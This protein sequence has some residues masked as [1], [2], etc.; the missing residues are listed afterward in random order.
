MSRSRDATGAV[1][2]AGV[3]NRQLKERERERKREGSGNSSSS[4]RSESRVHTGS[5]GLKEKNAVETA[6]A[7]RN[8]SHSRRPR[9]ETTPKRPTV[10]ETAGQQE[11]SPKERRLDST[12]FG[13]EMASLA[14]CD[15]RG[16][17]RGWDGRGGGSRRG[18]DRNSELERDRGGIDGHRSGSDSRSLTACELTGSF[19]RMLAAMCARGKK[20]R[21]HDS[22]GSCQSFL[23]HALLSLCLC[24]FTKAGAKPATARLIEP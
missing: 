15:S 5:I 8:A 22:R 19:D 6:K 20:G 9:R 10:S 4:G 23:E 13:L 16:S 24:C 3:A 21:E 2:R 7:R 11:V 17:Q 18:G 12:A 14:S 1:Q